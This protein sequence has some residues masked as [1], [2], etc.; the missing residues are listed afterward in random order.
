MKTYPKLG[1][2]KLTLVFY[3]INLVTHVNNVMFGSS[4]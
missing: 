1:G 3:L 2:Q 4:T